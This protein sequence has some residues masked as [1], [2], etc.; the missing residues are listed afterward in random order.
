MGAAQFPLLEARRVERP[1]SGPFSLD[2][3]R[4]YCAWRDAKLAAYPTEPEALRV[5]VSRLG[6][7]SSS[8]RAAIASLCRRA[9]MAIYAAAAAGDDETAI[10]RDLR[11][12]G[13]AFGLAAVEDHRS[14]EPDGIVRIEVV[15]QGGRL[16]YIPYTDRPINWHTDGYYNFHGP[17]R[18]IQAMLLHCVRGAAEGGTN[19]LLD[20]E[21]AYIRLRD[22]NPDFIAAFMHPGALTIPASVEAD[23]SI[24]REN[25]GP[26]FYVDPRSGALGMRFTARKRY[27]VWRDDPSTRSALAALEAILADDP[28][29]AQ[30][31]LR[32]GEGLICNNVLHDRSGFN[33]LAPPGRGRLM[34]RIR[35]GGRVMEDGGW[36]NNSGAGPWRA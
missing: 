25:V 5:E 32:P 33:P 19:R 30:V 34:Y 18:C 24:R 26:V 1:R 7:P 22:S 28:L 14:A 29:I 35:Y 6:A 12:F 11:A 4:A 9:N 23:G 8:E 27:V 13:A 17:Q 20:F 36:A 16:G 31:R 2:D 15:D 3:E 21:I 10:R